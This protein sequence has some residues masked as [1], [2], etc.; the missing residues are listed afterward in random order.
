MSQSL[1]PF[2][3]YLDRYEAQLDATGEQLKLMVDQKILE[4]RQ[5][6]NQWFR[7]ISEIA[8]SAFLLE[9]FHSPT[10]LCLHLWLS[11]S[12]LITPLV[13]MTVLIL[14][15]PWTILFRV[16]QA[17]NESELQSLVERIANGHELTLS[18][19]K[20]TTM[21]RSSIQVPSRSKCSR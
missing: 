4:V 17:A 10:I 7:T 5:D 6:V 3:D 16:H 9:V 8:F 2:L 20:M 18:M 11:T 13:A 19:I 21:V 1:D 15:L 12:M 14:F